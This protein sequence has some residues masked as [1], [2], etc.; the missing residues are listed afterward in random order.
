MTG[1]HVPQTSDAFCTGCHPAADV[2]L[3]HATVNATVN[4]PNVP[5]GLNNFFYE[6]A[7]AVVDPTTNNL[8]IK[9]R[10]QQNSGSL[11]AAK[12]NV[13]LNGTATNPLTGYTG[14]PGFLLA[15]YQDTPVQPAATNSADYNNLGVKAAQPKTV[16]IGSLLGGTNGTLG[17]PDADGFYTATV[18]S[19][20]AFPVG[21]TLRA[22]GLQGYFTQA[23]GTNGITAATARH[24]LSVVK[25]VT[26]DTIRREVIDSQKCGRC[27]EWFEAHGGN[28]VAGLGTVGQSICT[29]CHVPNLTSSGRGIQQS[30]LQFII[31]NP[32]GTSLAAVTNFVTGT[33]FSGTVSEEAKA[34][35]AAL[36]ASLGSDPTTYPE[37]S[38][39]FKDMIHGVHAGSNSLVVGIPLQFVRD[40]GASGEFDFNFQGVTFVGVLKDCRAC[41]RDTLTSAGAV[42][43]SR[44]TYTSIPDR[45]QSSTQVV[46][47]G[48]PL[49][50]QTAA[51]GAGNNVT[52]V[53][54]DRKS[55]PN[56][57]DL[58]N[59]PFTAT[60]RACHSMPNALAHFAQM[61]GS[62]NTPRAQA[63]KAAE[64][65]VTC[66]GT[67]G[68][69]ALF[70]VHRFSVVED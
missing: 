40:R 69:N 63:D 20:A 28:R 9:F 48:V 24:A 51:T 37:S 21:A 41:H 42:D 58:V 12:T 60:C 36:V 1:N 52:Q 27:H 18:N 47:S 11:T 55:V 35:N 62:V 31:D 6:I 25:E 57:Q 17:T 59:T 33:A 46:T 8:T 49:T 16:S 14:G 2:E 70:N 43:N 50:L 68:P 13:V 38:N 54:L 7:S 44:A 26:G 19:A 45:V 22:V 66:H 10:I 23:A 39:N 67:T 3:R 32:V 4:N 64:A 53:D 5:T 56:A 65:C 29:L 15:Y 34:A 30:L 61:G